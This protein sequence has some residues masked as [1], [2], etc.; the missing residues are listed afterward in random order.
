MLQQVFPL[1]QTLLSRWLDDS[2]VVEVGA[3]A[4]KSVNRLGCQLIAPPPSR[5]CA[6]FSI[7]RSELSSMILD[8]WWRS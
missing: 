5:Q 1:I 8:P 7:S 6:G 4:S 3:A 2:E